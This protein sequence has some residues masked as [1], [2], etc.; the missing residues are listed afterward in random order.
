M[1]AGADGGDPL[2]GLHRRPVGE[3]AAV[4][5][6][7]GVQHAEASLGD[8]QAAGLVAGAVRVGDGVRTAVAGGEEPAQQRVGGPADVGQREVCLDQPGD[9]QRCFVDV[10]GGDQEAAGALVGLHPRP[11]TD[12]PDHSGGDQGLQLLDPRHRRTA[13]EEVVESAE[14]AV[15]VVPVGRAPDALVGDH[16]P[17]LVPEVAHDR[18]GGLER[19]PG[20]SDGGL[21][22]VPPEPAGH[23]L[24]VL[25]PVGEPPVEAGPVDPLPVPVR[26]G[27]RE[28][29]GD[30]LRHLLAAPVQKA[31]SG[32]ELGALGLRRRAQQAAVVDVA[33]LLGHVRPQIALEVRLAAPGGAAQLGD[34]VRRQEPGLVARDDLQVHLGPRRVGQP[35]ARPR[36]QGGL[37]AG[38]QVAQSSVRVPLEPAAA[39]LGEQRDVVE[40]AE[41]EAAQHDGLTRAERGQVGL[42]GTGG[43]LVGQ[44]VL[45]GEPLQLL[46]PP[47]GSDVEVPLGQH[48]GVEQQRFVRVLEPQRLGAARHV[49]ERHRARAVDPDV[50][51]GRRVADDVTQRPAQIGTVEGPAAVGPREHPARLLA[52]RVADVRDVALGHHA[53]PLVLGRPGDDRPLAQDRLV[54][55]HRH[56]GGH[57]VHQQRAVLLLPPDPA[58]TGR[59]GIDQVDLH[60]HPRCE[61]R[62]VD[63]EAFERDDAARAGTYD[64][65]ADDRTADCHW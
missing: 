17:D 10:G 7:G 16:L 59:V 44:P 43:R 22:H 13:G 18:R 25:G 8:V 45:G 12:H 21:L 54:G 34:H 11:G 26:G 64:A 53:G 40:E 28:P 6:P 38:G 14:P 31:V 48:D 57:G 65:H 49:L 63:A 55:E 46:L 52:V 51:G 61:E 47:G 62:G 1:R 56:V 39:T 58:A 27:V 60:R 5:G 29:F 30:Q 33:D 23:P 9:H 36:V 15:D 4:G 24:L 35:S 19:A 3:A 37:P 41:A 20:R 32:E 42:G 2:D 50:D